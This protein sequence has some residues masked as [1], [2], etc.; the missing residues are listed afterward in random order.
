MGF[1]LTSEAVIMC[2][3]GGKVQP[4]PHQETVTIQGAPVLCLGDLVGAPVIG[5]PLASPTTKPCTTVLAP[6]PGS[7][8]TSMFI[9]GM[10]VH[11][12]SFTAATDG[13]PPAT[14]IVEFAGQEIVQA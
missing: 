10:P 2:D 7:V 13:V 4:I 11:V 9:Q 12:D 3:H 6:L 8:S 5:C 1:V 14:V